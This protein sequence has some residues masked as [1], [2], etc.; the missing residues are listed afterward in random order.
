MMIIKGTK[1][2][3][4]SSLLQAGQ[5]SFEVGVFVEIVFFAT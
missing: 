5:H 2:R 1:N 4:L 3:V